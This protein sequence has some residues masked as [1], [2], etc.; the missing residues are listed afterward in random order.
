MPTQAQ[1]AGTRV[2][3][4]NQQS[5]KFV[6]IN[7]GGTRSSKSHSIL[8]LLTLK[9]FNEEDKKILIIRKTMPSLRLSI[10]PIWQKILRELCMKTTD[11]RQE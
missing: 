8:Q 4:E 9:F 1:L 2:F 3:F 7:R 10:W 6:N 11:L 5:K